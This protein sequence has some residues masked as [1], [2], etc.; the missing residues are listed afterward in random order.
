MIN[1]TFSDKPEVKGVEVLGRFQKLGS[2]FRV[3]RFV[4]QS[5]SAEFFPF[6]MDTLER[7]LAK[8]GETLAITLTKRHHVL[9]YDVDFGRLRTSL[10]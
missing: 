4:P 3:R 1:K 8:V 10:N 9:E 5:I 6:A 2:I 7:L